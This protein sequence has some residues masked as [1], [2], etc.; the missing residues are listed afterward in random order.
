MVVET[1]VRTRLL[2]DTQAGP[3]ELVERAA[4]GWAPA[5]LLCAE[6]HAGQ[7]YMRGYC[8]TRDAD[9]RTLY[10]AGASGVRRGEDG[11]TTWQDASAGL[12]L[13]DIWGLEA[14]PARPGTVFAGAKAVGIFRSD[15]G[16][17][18]WQE[19]DMAAVPGQEV[20]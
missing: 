1:A 5:R 11:G 18:S 14:H 7:R 3:V 20:W 6:S 17:E 16:G 13:T 19:T 12:R 9:G 2:L 4:D 15:D 10:V 8:L